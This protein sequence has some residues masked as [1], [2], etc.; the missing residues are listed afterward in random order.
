[1]ISSE[2]AKDQREDNFRHHGAGLSPGL[3]LG[4]FPG[5]NPKPPLAR[6]TDPAK[7]ASHLL[8][9]P[10]HLFF[11]ST[12]FST[13]H[14]IP[15]PRP[16]AT[17]TPLPPDPFSHCPPPSSFNTSS[18]YSDHPGILGS[19]PDHEPGPVPPPSLTLP[20]LRDLDKVARPDS[21]PSSALGSLSR[22]S[23]PHLRQHF[24][25]SVP[26]RPGPHQHFAY[27][28]HSRQSSCAGS[29]PDLYMG[30]TSA[31]ST[32]TTSSLSRADSLSSMEYLQG[33]HPHHR[34]RPS[35]RHPSSTTTEST[36]SSYGYSGAASS[37]SSGSQSLPL[38]HYQ[39]HH[40]TGVGR[41]NLDAA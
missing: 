26:Q 38:H 34:N 28:H 39:Y 8:D 31:P 9:R 41:A 30:S 6:G 7:P 4:H 13:A 3:S 18:H 23:D 22:S 37:T 11:V 29:L 14:S 2:R 35:F 27:D 33:S 17:P 12:T 24:P 19:G 15:L 21:H 40:S 32:T 10:E 16:A 1:M 36:G 20:S 25:Q 5:L